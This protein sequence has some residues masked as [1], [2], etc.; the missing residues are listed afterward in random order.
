M[1]DNVSR[2]QLRIPAVAELVALVAADDI[3]ACL[4]ML[5][6]TVVDVVDVA[7]DPAVREALAQWREQGRVS[8]TTRSHLAHA[9]TRGELDAAA[10]HR[11]ADVHR[12]RAA[13]RRARALHTLVI[14]IDQETDARHRLGEA[15]Y[16]ASIAMGGTAGV[17]AV[18]AEFLA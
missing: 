2:V 9:L 11:G 18:L 8:P 12:Q 10:A 5:S 4:Q 1:S 6:T 14:A 17:V 13:F 3:E 15:S 16:E 7:A